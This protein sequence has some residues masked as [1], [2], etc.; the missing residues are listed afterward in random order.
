MN[1]YLANSRALGL[2]VATKEQGLTPM[3]AHVLQQRILDVG[4]HFF[5]TQDTLIELGV[6]P[7]GIGHFPVVAPPSRHKD[8]RRPDVVVPTD[9]PLDGIPHHVDVNG[10][11]LIVFGKVEEVHMT[12]ECRAILQAGNVLNYVTLL[13][14]FEDGQDSSVLRILLHIVVVNFSQLPHQ[15][16]ELHASGFGHPIEKQNVNLRLGCVVQFIGT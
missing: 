3:I 13:G 10:S 6:D 5:A 2:V 7:L 16:N 12:G 14:R 9:H 4:A 1:F 8:P 15:L 11:G